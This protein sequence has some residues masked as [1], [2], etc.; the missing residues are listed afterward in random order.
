MKRH[1]SIFLM[2]FGFLIVFSGCHIFKK[3][4]SRTNSKV[5][6]FDQFYQRFHKDVDFQMSRLQFPLQG[7]MVDG[8]RIENW[9]RQNWSPLKVEIYDVDQG[10]FEVTFERTATSFYQKFWTEDAG[11]FAEYRFELVGKQWFLVYAQD[12]NL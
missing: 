9:S 8:D 1:I 2:L 5:E 7:Q 6:D 10:E 12:V 3:G 11:F 4:P